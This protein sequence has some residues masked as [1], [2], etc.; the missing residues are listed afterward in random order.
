MESEACSLL[1]K[2]IDAFR[3]GTLT[4]EHLQGLNE[5]LRQ[6][7]RLQDLLYLQTA[8]TSVASKVIG[9]TML[10]GGEIDDGPADYEDWPYK[11]V[12]EAICDGWRVIRFPAQVPAA[13]SQ[14]SHVI[15]EFVLER[16][17]E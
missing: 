13:H 8:T 4:E 15:C 17:S 10:R 2:C 5:A 14:D 1:Q 16:F 11:T 12:A 6:R 3:E 7:P 9:T